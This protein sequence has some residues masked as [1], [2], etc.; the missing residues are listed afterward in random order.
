MERSSL[1]FFP[2]DILESL[3]ELI[4]AQDLGHLL[5]TGNTV[6]RSKLRAVIR[7][8]R[9]TYGPGV[10]PTWPKILFSSLSRLES[11]DLGMHERFSDYN[12]MVYNTNFADLPKSLKTIRIG[13]LSFSP[14]KY[15][16]SRYT[17]RHLPSSADERTSNIL[18][19]DLK[20][21]FP[22]L[23]HLYTHHQSTT[24]KNDPNHFLY[25][26]LPLVSLQLYTL[27]SWAISQL[28]STLTYLK[29]RILH[30]D[31]TDEI[32]FPP[33]LQTLQVALPLTFKSKRY[34]LP[35]LPS[36]LLDL[37]ISFPTL[38]ADDLAKVP[39][40]VKKLK[41][42]QVGVSV[43]FPTTEEGAAAVLPP[44][45]EHLGL[46]SIQIPFSNLSMLPK[47]LKTLHLSN[48]PAI[49][50]NWG[51]LP[52]TLV[53]LCASWIRRLKPNDW[54]LL[55]RTL[56][57]MLTPEQ[58]E[59]RGNISQKWPVVYLP[60]DAPYLADLPP[61]IERLSIHID[62]SSILDLEAVERE[63]EKSVS[64][65]HLDANASTKSKGFKGVLPPGIK[66]MTI[67]VGELAL[68][69]ANKVVVPAIL[70]AL[71]SH[72][73]KIDVS[74][75]LADISTE[76]TWEHPFFSFSSDSTIIH[77]S[78]N[79]TK[80]SSLVPPT[81]SPSSKQS[82]T[83]RIANLKFLEISSYIAV[84]ESWVQALPEEIEEFALSPQNGSPSLTNGSILRYLPSSLTIISVTVQNIAEGDLCSLPRGLLK[85]VA[86]CPPENATYPESDLQYLPRYLCR[87]RLPKMPSSREEW[88]E[89]GLPYLPLY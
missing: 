47:A 50:S 61:N 15:P 22:K 11:V 52:P 79:R 18:D 36:D 1:L 32:N 17:E 71:A 51:N 60:E 12:Y 83:T 88:D 70:E 72:P 76:D 40:G 33:N 69:L 46:V 65:L 35:K 41:I 9:V 37:E 30:A 19:L 55:P 78:K 80:F 6:L 42:G 34:V 84:P 64:M 86:S 62:F 24:A 43:P 3:C 31:S 21:E 49:G 77:E 39:Q 54:K 68:K 7:S 89:Y 29:L 67:E 2:T 66:T 73:H 82:T 53:E 57:R 20:A 81:S 4:S 87:I 38:S 26:S 48:Q 75:I 59:A 28:P 5:L 58:I 45:L 27:S 74:V 10:R 23:E 14:S 8:V 63:Q 13:E 16:L 85:L 25:A 56:R 44:H